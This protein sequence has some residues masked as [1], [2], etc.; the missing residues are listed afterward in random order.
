ML[1]PILKLYWPSSLKSSHL[2]L[3]KFALFLSIII[4]RIVSIHC[5]HNLIQCTYY[6]V[7]QIGQC[8]PI[9]IFRTL[10][11]LIIAFYKFGELPYCFFFF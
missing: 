4:I 6:R 1:G 9:L 10:I 7:C 5:K 2:Q 8:L 3:R 11:Y